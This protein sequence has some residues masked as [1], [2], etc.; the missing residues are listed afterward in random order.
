MDIPRLQDR[1]ILNISPNFSQVVNFPT[2]LNPDKILDKIVTSLSHWY[3]PPVPLPALE[4]DDDKGG[5]PSDHLGV[6][7]E[8]LSHE[9]PALNMREVTFRPHPDSSVEAFGRWVSTYTWDEVYNAE[10]AHEKA[11]IFQNIIFLKSI[12]IFSLRKLPSSDTMINHGL[13]VK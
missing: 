9:Y 11:D 4:C 12:I 5:K 3:H 10:T 6:Y 8:P 1:A 13:L 2:R 7:W